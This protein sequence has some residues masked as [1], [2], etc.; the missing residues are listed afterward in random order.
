MATGVIKKWLSERSFGFIKPDGVGGD[1]FFHLNCFRRDA[2]PQ[3]GDR[4]SFE[5]E[6]SSRS[7]EPQAVNVRL[8]D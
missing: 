4:V 2:E 5:I 6:N 8:S 1:V 3:A 7:G